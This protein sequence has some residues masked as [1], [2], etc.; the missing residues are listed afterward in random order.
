MYKFEEKLEAIKAKG[1]YRKMLYLEAPQVPYTIIDGE[2]ILML[3]S[4]S[5]LGLCNDDR[6]KEAAI[7][8]IREFGVGAGGSRLTT[9]SYKLH[10]ELE[11]RLAEFKSTEACLVFSTGYAANIGTISAL[12]DKDWVVFCDRLNHASIIDGCRLSGAKLIIYRHADMDDLEKKIKRYHHGKGL[13]V[14]DG[15]FSM[16]GDIAP[17]PDIVQQAQKY[18][19]MTMVDDAH[20]TGVLGPNGG[21]TVDFFSLKDKVDIQMGTLSK[22]FASEGGYIAGKLSL[23][24]YLRHKAK[25]FIYSTALAPHNIAVAL[26]ALE[27]IQKEPETRTSLLE[28]SLWF[29]GELIENGFVV[30]ENHSP[31]IPLMVGEAD[32]AVEFSRILMNEGVYVPAIRPPTVPAG[33]SRLRFSI[34]ATHN[35]ED[36]KMAIKKIKATGDKLV[37]NYKQR[38]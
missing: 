6:L 32:Q 29:R 30:P 18:N 20:A 35:Y 22:A 12:V 26:K 10:R 23:I 17:I 1:L 33:T 8:A 24:D 19:L 25:S 28:K 37:L 7:A 36:L 11:E 4:N 2:S 34:M 13:I 38:S 31:I 14:T 16:D 21:G 15:I 5:Y 9:G 3:S 27:I